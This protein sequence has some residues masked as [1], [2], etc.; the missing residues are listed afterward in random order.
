M[1]VSLLCGC[2]DT[3]DSPQESDPPDY[4]ATMP[5][6]T[7]MDAAKQCA[8]EIDR[9]LF[10]EPAGISGGEG[11]WRH[12]ETELFNANVIDGE[13]HLEF[14]PTHERMAKATCHT[15]GVEVVSMTRA[16]FEQAMRGYTYENYVEV[17]S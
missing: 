4:R 17:A 2:A 7:V 10:L 9:T 15:N 6:L 14:L 3:A 12:Y 5:K 8:T 13:W 11:F 16:E 1:A